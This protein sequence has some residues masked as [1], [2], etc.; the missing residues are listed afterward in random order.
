MGFTTVRRFEPCAKR[1]GERAA[2]VVAGQMA[3]DNRLKNATRFSVT[4]LLSTAIL[5]GPEAEFAG[6]SLKG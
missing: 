3:R 6:R 4:T 2:K 1:P 5:S